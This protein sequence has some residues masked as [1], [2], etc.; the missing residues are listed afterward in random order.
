[1][2]QHNE[3]KYLISFSSV[4]SLITHFHFTYPPPHFLL[5]RPPPP[6]VTKRG[7]SW[8]HTVSETCCG[9]EGLNREKRDKQKKLI[10]KF[11]F[12]N[13]IKVFPKHW[14]C[15]C[16]FTS[17]M[18]SYGLSL[19]ALK[20]TQSTSNQGQGELVTMP[21]P[22]FKI[23]EASTS[24]TVIQGNRLL[25]AICYEACICL[26]KSCFPVFWS[27]RVIPTVT[28]PSPFNLF[29]PPFWFAG[30]QFWVFKDT[31]LQSGYPKDITQ[32]GHGMPAQSIETAVWWEDV[33]KT[34]FFKGDRLVHKWQGTI[35]KNLIIQTFSNFLKT[36]TIQTIKKCLSQ[37]HRI[38][39]KAI[40]HLQF[41]GRSRK[42]TNH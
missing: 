23:R 11:K 13:I 42:D 19:P 22:Y 31:V 8:G 4:F 10:W 14:G 32:F 24:N 12:F 29:S 36:A 21:V 27:R 18:R 1:M 30:K 25:P 2:S 33:A 38:E 37:S 16:V 7:T 9:R 17:G 26:N 20:R 39:L 35:K 34:Y 6:P 3:P 15:C 40:F 5:V 28:R 41:C